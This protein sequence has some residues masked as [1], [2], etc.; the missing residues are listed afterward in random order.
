MVDC[1]MNTEMKSQN[2]HNCTL[3]SSF[4][5]TDGHLYVM[6][7]K[8]SSIAFDVKRNEEQIKQGGSIK[9][10]GSKPTERYNY[11]LFWL[12]ICFQSSKLNLF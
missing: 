10:R 2:K 3:Q 4:L 7:R 12:P 8:N 5:K 6:I 11:S 1:Y 9:V